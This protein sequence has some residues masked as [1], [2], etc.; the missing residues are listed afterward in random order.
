GASLRQC[1]S[2]HCSGSSGRG[3][4]FKPCATVHLQL[5]K[6]VPLHRE[7]GR[8]QDEMPSADRM[9]RRVLGTGQKIFSPRV[10]PERSWLFGAILRRFPCSREKLGRRGCILSQRI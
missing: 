7:C 4:K 8:P 1:P 2:R 9:T 5:P 3:G 6:T 10:T